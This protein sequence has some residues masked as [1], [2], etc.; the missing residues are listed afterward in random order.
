VTAGTVG[1]TDHLA[2]IDLA[3]PRV[4]AEQDLSETWRRLRSDAPVHWHPATDRHDGFWV[5][6]R[7]ADVAGVYRDSERFTSERGNVLD[8]LLDGGD[9]AAGKMAAITDGRRHADLRGI[10]LKAFS[11]R[12]L[13]VVVDNV[14]SATNRLVA[15]ALARGECDFASDVAAGI[16]LMAICDLLGVPQADR[17]RILTLTSSALASDRGV[18]TAEDT[19]SARIEI[20]HYFLPDVLSLLA[21]SEVDGAPLTHDEIIYNCYSLIMGGDETTRFS[22]IGGVLALIENPAQWRALKDGTVS[23][24]SA[25]E[26]VLRWTT[27]TLHAGRTATEDVLLGGRFIE[28]GDIVTVWNA[29]AN[30]DERQFPDPDTFD[31]SR[32][33]NKH[34]TFAYGPHFCLG[35]YLARVE[36]GAVLEALRDTATDI[37]LTGP[38]RRVYSNFLSGL[39]SLPLALRGV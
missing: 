7:Y 39:Y 32:K 6:T 22:M 31:L 1:E 12:A 38:V 2:N 16:P 35:A 8:T 5:I 9:R 34:L 36:I 27:P 24:E 20:L 3:D 21:G 15:E 13:G 23:I 33:P 29:S 25:V 10:M 26:E 37:E 30:R 11:P 28:A 17:S 14:R 4:H 19:W 18:P